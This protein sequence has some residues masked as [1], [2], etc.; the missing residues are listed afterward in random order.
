MSDGASLTPKEAIDPLTKQV[1]WKQVTILKRKAVG[2]EDLK[3]ARAI[4]KDIFH[5]IGRTAKTSSATFYGNTSLPGRRALIPSS[6]WHR[7]ANSP[8]MPK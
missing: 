5:V 4:G 7:T 8:E 1:K 3:K 6:P 2:E